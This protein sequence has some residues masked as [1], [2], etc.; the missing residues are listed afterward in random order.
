MAPRDD[1]QVHYVPHYFTSEKYNEL[2]LK[3]T[4]KEKR[5]TDKLLKNLLWRKIQLKGSFALKKENNFYHVLNL[6]MADI[7]PWK[8]MTSRAFGR[9]V[10]KAVKSLL[11]NESCVKKTIVRVCQRSRSKDKL[12]QYSTGN[13][14]WKQL[15]GMKHKG[16]SQLNFTLPRKVSKSIERRGAISNIYG[17]F[18]S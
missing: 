8:A 5:K 18:R 15:N 11:S 10:S 14:W 9:T 17:T 1:L 3:I 4:R 2:T 6:I 16:R 13:F 12:V 7:I